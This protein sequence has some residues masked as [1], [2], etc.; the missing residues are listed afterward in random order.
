MGGNIPG[1]NFPEGNFPRTIA[2]A[3][4]I[5]QNVQDQNDL[6]MSKISQLR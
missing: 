3:L 4:L 6:W 5:K 2:E 1:G